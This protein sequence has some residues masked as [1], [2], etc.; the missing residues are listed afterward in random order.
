MSA[1]FDF[2]YDVDYLMTAFDR[3]RAQHWSRYVSTVLF[4]LALVFAAA[5]AYREFTR[6][7]FDGVALGALMFIA[8]YMSRSFMRRLLRRRISKMAGLGDGFVIELTSRGMVAKGQGQEA[9]LGW[10]RFAHA[11]RYPDGFLLVQS[12]RAFNW[13]PLSALSPDSSAD[14]VQMLIEQG[15]GRLR[16]RGA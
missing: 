5:Y 8:V 7:A 16:T 3:H 1:R 2:R 9:T 14:D 13:L 4:A 11:V 15:L 12:Q 10:D 6:G